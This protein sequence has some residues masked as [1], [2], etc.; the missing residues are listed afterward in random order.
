MGGIHRR[1]VG[2]CLGVVVDLKHSGGCGTRE[3]F[4]IDFPPAVN[5]SDWAILGP[6]VGYPPKTVADR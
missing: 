3:A 6:L 4:G 5:A 2:I 1:C